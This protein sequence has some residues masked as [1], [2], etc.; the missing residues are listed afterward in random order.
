MNVYL[1]RC[2]L[3]T[4]VQY[5]AFDFWKNAFVPPFRGSL[6]STVPAHGCRILALRPVEDHPFLIGTSRHITQGIIDVK[7]ERWDSAKN[8]IFGQSEVVA[9]D[10]YELRIYAPQ[11]WKVQS[12]GQ[13]QTAQEG[14]GV[15]VMINP[16]KTG[17]LNWKVVFVK[18]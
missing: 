11:G 15:R 2:D 13:W 3:P 12:A 5:V 9:D 18:E 7:S 6:L 4:N 1:A 17:P 14:T 8:T 10:P 16:A